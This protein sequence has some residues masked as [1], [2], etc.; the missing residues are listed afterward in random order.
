[1]STDPTPVSGHGA[2]GRTEPRRP[3]PVAV[4]GTLAEFHREPIPYDLPALVGLVERIRPDLLCLDLTL[5]Q[6]QSGDFG[7]LPPEYREALL[8]L[9]RR[10][11]IVV[12]PIAEDAPPSDPLPAGLRGWLIGRIR[13]LL[14]WLQ[15]GASGPDA[16]NEGP[17]HLVA[18]GLYGLIGLL[19]G[20]DTRRAWNRHR[21]SLVRGT[22][23]VVE[24]D[25]D[26]R[27]LV[28]VN[29]RHCHHIR[30]ALRGRADVALAGHSRL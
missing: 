14:G 16:V 1:M 26:R 15:R 7:G 30:E 17:R 3:T 2:V 10:S 11:D 12:I 24:R 19:S 6:W 22:L 13:G 8:P 21:E 28:V 29:A 9:A 25:P 4:L 23:S 20:A 5:A 27:I 18:D